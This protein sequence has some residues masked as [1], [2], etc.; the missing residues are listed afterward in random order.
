MST[1][2]GLTNP[3]STTGPVTTT[4]P[5][6]TT[7]P[8]T[9]TGPVSTT[10]PVSTT[11]PVSTTDKP[12]TIIT[13]LSGN[14]INGTLTIRGIINRR[15]IK[16][17]KNITV[18]DK[19]NNTIGT[20]KGPWPSG[21]IVSSFTPT[22]VQPSKTTYSVYINVNS[23]NDNILNSSPIPVDV[24][25]NSQQNNTP[26]PTMS[27]NDNTNNNNNSNPTTKPN[28][29]NMLKDTSITTLLKSNLPMPGKV[30]TCNNVL[31]FDASTSKYQFSQ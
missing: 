26:T 28:I 29:M 8:I 30:Q 22:V 24:T 18:L 17:I 7:G 10:K 27:T 9:T 20:M 4:N 5:V 21:K 11:G 31:N 3:I 12:K 2:E 15:Y 14:Y 6:N 23:H 13:N 19:N 16:S 1:S 25:I